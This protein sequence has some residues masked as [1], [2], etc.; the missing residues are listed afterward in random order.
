MGTARSEI[1]KRDKE[2]GNN[3]YNLGEKH[4]ARGEYTKAIE[5]CTKAIELNP[6]NADAYHLRG[7]NYYKLSLYIKAI[8]DFNKASELN[9]KYTNCYNRM[10]Y[11]ELQSAIKKQASR[12]EIIKI[13]D[14][15]L[16]NTT[17]KT[18]KNALNY[19]KNEGISYEECKEQYIKCYNLAF[20][21]VFFAEL[22]NKKGIVPTKTE[23]HI[24]HQKELRLA[25]FYLEKGENWGGKTVL[26]VEGLGKIFKEAEEKS[27]EKLSEEQV[28]NIL[29][30]NLGFKDNEAKYF[31]KK[32]YNDKPFFNMLKNEPSFGT[33]QNANRTINKLYFVKNQ[34]DVNTIIN[35]L[36][37]LRSVIGENVVIN[38]NRNA[39]NFVIARTYGNIRDMATKM[40]IAII[41]TDDERNILRKMLEK[42]NNSNIYDQIRKYETE[43][44][45]NVLSNLDIFG[46]YAYLTCTR[47]LLITKY[48]N[49]T[50]FA[51]YLEIQQIPH[52][53]QYV[54]FSKTIPYMIEG[55]TEYDVLN[56]ISKIVIRTDELFRFN[57]WNVEEKAYKFGTEV[58]EVIRKSEQ[59]FLRRMMNMAFERPT[60]TDPTLKTTGAINKNAMEQKT[61]IEVTEDEI[62]K[63][64]SI[65]APELISEFDLILRVEGVKYPES[66]VNS[67]RRLMSGQNLEYLKMQQGKINLVIATDQTLF[68]RYLN[69]LISIEP[70]PDIYTKYSFASISN[71]SYR[72]IN[73]KT[74]TSGE[75]PLIE[76]KKWGPQPLILVYG[77]IHAQNDSTKYML[78]S[79]GESLYQLG[80]AVNYQGKVDIADLNNQFNGFVDAFKDD[81]NI[82]VYLYL[83]NEKDK[84]SKY[85]VVVYKKDGG[86]YMKLQTYELD[87]KEAADIFGGYVNYNGD[88]RILFMNNSLKGLVV[89]YQF[90]ETGLATLTNNDKN[91]LSVIFSMTGDS[92]KIGARVY[93]D[94][95]GANQLGFRMER[96]VSV[97]NTIGKEKDKVFV[98]TA[99]GK[100]EDK[101]IYGINLKMQP[102]NTKISAIALKHLEQIFAFGVNT[103]NSYFLLD[104]IKS[105]ESKKGNKDSI[106]ITAG[107]IINEEAFDLWWYDNA[108]QANYSYEN[109]VTYTLKKLLE[110]RD[111]LK[112]EMTAGKIDEVQAKITYINQRIDALKI[113]L[114][115]QMRRAFKIR[116]LNGQRIEYVGAESEFINFVQYGEEKSWRINGSIGKTKSV[117]YTQI[118][119][120]EK[121]IVSLLSAN[122]LNIDDITIFSG[123][124]GKSKAPFESEGGGWF[125]E[126]ASTTNK[127]ERTVA[128]TGA[129]YRW[130][131][132]HLKLKENYQ[133]VIGKVEG[134]EKLNTFSL[135][136]GSTSIAFKENEQ[137]HKRFYII[138][139]GAQTK[140]N[141]NNLV[142]A[143]AGELGFTIHSVTIDEVQQLGI[144]I[145][146]CKLTGFDK[147]A[148]KV[149]I[150]AYGRWEEPIY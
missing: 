113:I 76:Y 48:G 70:M 34:L 100:E 87:K 96:K 27:K 142:K 131:E 25:L 146:A 97:D 50:Q 45:S 47:P 119:Q 118:A 51:K 53:L 11:D 56:M 20:P 37:D 80:C 21:P 150:I 9:S 94:K 19:F 112:K 140:D 137:I 13:I 121:E 141:F 123:R 101:I 98:D 24:Q 65:L 22:P 103:N 18:L 107:T 84:E 68:D 116:L 83:K 59:S 41:K 78:G 1:G 71:Y 55:N 124:Y 95:D 16:E 69:E 60:A 139:N 108:R 57:M 38:L 64:L 148:T 136:Y 102:E 42:I 14:E 117:E 17:N 66:T 43:H 5:E 128:L 33:L 6:K 12:K 54:L 135:G 132:K 35:E 79:K 29:K 4:Y 114:G 85:N 115:R 67:F 92:N 127:K 120:K 63:F 93:T 91:Q 62:R 109:E 88:A 40:E 99:V 26:P 143:L 39:L 31:A 89:G 73:G 138:L 44:G 23:E 3:H 106:G 129:Y 61:P 149:E 125:G 105:I 32:I 74:T 111:N 90:N 15:L 36:S 28:M 133:T 110:E 7:I 10:L 77:S 2:D 104:Y 81:A 75:A 49:S 122:V 126:V 145:T 82:L 58:I 72:Q 130:N 46:K 134:G 144:N 52:Q 8:A 147:K 30:N 86:Q